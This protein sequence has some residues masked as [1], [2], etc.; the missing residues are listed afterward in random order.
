MKR[1][2][3]LL[4]IAVMLFVA[5]TMSAQKHKHL[6]STELG[7]GYS[8]M[9]SNSSI[10]K[11]LGLAG[12]NL[13][14]GYEWNW[15]QFMLH[16]GIEFASINHTLRVHDFSISTPYTI[17]LPSHIEMVEHFAFSDF[18]E[19]QCQGILNL[20]IMAGAIFDEKYYFLA[21]VKLGLP[22]YSV[23]NS[24]THVQTSLSD[25]TLIG[26]LTGNI[27][28][29]DV[30][31]TTETAHHQ[32]HAA[33]FTAQASA[34]LG[35]SI[36]GFL[37]KKKKGRSAY[38]GSSKNQPLPKYYRVGIFCDYGLT[39]T[40][41]AVATP[42]AS[43]ADVAQPRDIALYS[44]AELGGKAHPFIIGVKGAILFQ[45]NRPK[46]PVQPASYLEVFVKDEDTKKAMNAQIAILDLKTNKTTTRSTRSGKLRTRTKLGS[47][48]VTASAVDYYSEMQPYTI[49]TLG[50]DVQLN[51]ALRHRPYFKLSV[52]DA[53]TAQAIAADVV[54]TNRNTQQVLLT[55]ST[56]SANGYL[57]R[58]LE[59]TI[60]YSITV[61][62]SGYES[63]MGDIR[64]ISDS[65]NIQLSPLK[66]GSVIVFKNMYFATSETTILPE[67]EEALDRLYQILNE[68]PD[69]RIRIIGHTDDVGSDADNQ[70]LSEGRA[71]SVRQAMLER[72]INSARIEIE[73]RGEKQPIDTNTTEEGRANNRRV[74]I[75][76]L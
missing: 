17:G 75:L 26:E 8:A 69:L 44:N 30:M 27:P 12:A 50:D 57:Q 19:R 41:P 9:F 16:T 76:V 35:V 56:D 10:A 2:F 22:V 64:A 40:L 28:V 7:L 6:L 5:A 59:D 14:V 49:E 1:P 20:P 68:N 4:I 48:E 36:N 66:K 60:P 34:E 38:A 53:N 65:M 32:L 63:F 51:F 11:D 67:S 25:P 21:G 37:K 45:L 54:F 71:G 43:I 29:H 13:Q 72:G 61:S 23:S 39:P 58:I 73:G 42:L 62:K 24:R 55:L 74:E 52:H 47:Y 70:I 18:V 15:N 3:R 33:T 31:L 46:K